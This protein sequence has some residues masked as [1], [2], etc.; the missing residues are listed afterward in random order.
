MAGW[1][2]LNRASCRFRTSAS[3]PSEL[4]G[5]VTMVGPRSLCP[6]QHHTSAGA[7]RCHHR[8]TRRGVALKELRKEDLPGTDMRAG[9]CVEVFCPEIALD[10][11]LRFGRS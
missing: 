7:S 3:A 8:W 1:S 10:A 9:N 5:K 11:R 6:A 4:P 2:A